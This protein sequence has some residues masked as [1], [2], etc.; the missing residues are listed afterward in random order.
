MS[1]QIDI[2]VGMKREMREM[3]ANFFTPRREAA[4]EGIYFAGAL[5]NA[6]G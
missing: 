5:V 4:K 3:E 2:A 1:E 6:A